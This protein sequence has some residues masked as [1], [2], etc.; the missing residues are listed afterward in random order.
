M[1][2]YITGLTLPFLLTVA[3]QAQNFPQKTHPVQRKPYFLWRQQV[4]TEEQKKK[5]HALRQEYRKNL[6]KL[7]R[8]DNITVKEWRAKLENLQRKRR[9]DLQSLLTPQQ[10]ARMERW[11]MQRNHF[12]LRR[13]IQQNLYDRAHRFHRVVPGLPHRWQ[14]RVVPDPYKKRIELMKRFQLQKPGKLS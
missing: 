14:Y 8:E 9:E 11:K 3:C 6:M 2:K 1:K 4:L 10:K 13:P 5:L 12:F 7:R